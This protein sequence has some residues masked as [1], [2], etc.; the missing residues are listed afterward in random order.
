MTPNPYL[1]G[2]QGTPLCTIFATFFYMPE[3]ISK[4]KTYKRENR[5]SWF[6]LS[7]GGQCVPKNRGHLPPAQAQSSE[8]GVCSPHLTDFIPAA[9]GRGVGSVFKRWNVWRGFSTQQTLSVTLLSTG[10][11]GSRNREKLRP[12]RSRCENSSFRCHSVVGNQERTPT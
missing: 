9:A 7:G 11:R 3:I 8:H 2:H 6:A 1:P 10:H 5:I 12:P 4:H